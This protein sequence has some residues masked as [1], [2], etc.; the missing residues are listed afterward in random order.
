MATSSSFNY[1]NFGLIGQNNNPTGF[2]NNWLTERS[3]ENLFT[4]KYNDFNLFT[5]N[6][7]TMDHSFSK[8]II[9]NIIEKTRLSNIFFSMTNVN[10]IKYLLARI[11]KQRLNYEITP[12]AQSTEEILTVMRSIYL[13]NSKNRDDNIKEQIIDL[14]YAVLLDLYPRTSSNIKHYLLYIRDHGSRPL[15]LDR[16]K[17]HSITGTKTNRSKEFNIL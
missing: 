16:P 17:N 7:N 5:E 10:H 12:S 13:S 14:N 2:T 4:T 8:N 3:H 6:K 11:I 1:D 9:S 15:P